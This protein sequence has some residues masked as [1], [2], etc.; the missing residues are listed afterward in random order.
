MEKFEI[1]QLDADYLKAFERKFHQS[2]ASML[3]GVPVFLA[4]ELVEDL[5]KYIE[6]SFTLTPIPESP[7]DS[8]NEGS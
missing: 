7:F 2:V 1:S 8:Q 4:K 6:G 3:I 5:P